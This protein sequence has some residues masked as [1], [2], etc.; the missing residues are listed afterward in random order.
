MLNYN[1]S[2]KTKIYNLIFSNIIILLFFLFWFVYSTFNVI[3][4]VIFISSYLSTII[5]LIFSFKYIINK[6]INLMETTTYILLLLIPGIFLLDL[7]FFL[8]PNINPFFF[9]FY[10]L[11][12]IKHAFKMGIFLPLLTLILLKLFII[13]IYFLKKPGIFEMGKGDEFFQY[14]TNDLNNEKLFSLAVLF[15]LSAF[16]EELIYRS[17][18]LSFLI[19]YFNFNLVVGI[20]FASLLFGLVHFSTKKY[21]KSSAVSCSR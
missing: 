15:P 8:I 19:Y 16:V 6:N 10:N 1:K 7:L 3:V 4:N 20:M 13:Y 18:I 21:H 14:F 11:I 17:L 12:G 5:V 2:I 9:S